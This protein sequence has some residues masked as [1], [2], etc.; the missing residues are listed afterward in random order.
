MKRPVLVRT[1]DDAEFT[2]PGTR[3]AAVTDFN[4]TGTAALTPNERSIADSR[5]VSTSTLD[6]IGQRMDDLG[7]DATLAQALAGRGGSEVL[8]NL[9]SDGVISPQERAALDTKDGLTKAGRER[10]SSLVLG[11]FFSDPAQM[12]KLA[13]ALRNKMERIA[14]PLARTEGAGGFDLSGHT[15]GA[16]DLIEDAAT[17]G[18]ANLDEHLTQDGLFGAQKY[19]PE[20]V[21]LARLLTKAKPNDLT[22]AVRN[23]AEHARYAREYQ[24]PGLF[25]EFP[26]PKTSRGAFNAAFGTALPEAGA[27]APTR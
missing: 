26:D 8:G 13:P 3:Q 7:P 16:L 24:G 25:K 15:R 12:D 19:S 20:A 17:H 9:I 2:Q 10:I 21:N 14:A 23:Y 4:K 22:A 1:L 11:R 27:G 5:R 6:D 18:A